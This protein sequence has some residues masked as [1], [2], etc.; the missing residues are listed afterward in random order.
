MIVRILGEGQ[1]EV[2]DDE[3][4]ELN[5]IDGQVAAAVSGRDQVALTASLRR[6]N[7]ELSRVGKPVADEE[8]RSSDLIL[9]GPDA[10]LDEVAGLLEDN[11]RSQGLIPG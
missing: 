1:L 6:L 7:E 2:P 4:N 3:V 5:A 8:L 11:G 10:T 9:P